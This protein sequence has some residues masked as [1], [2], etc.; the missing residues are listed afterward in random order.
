MHCLCGC[1]GRRS[2]LCDIPARRP[3]LHTCMQLT[4]RS[5]LS[6]RFSLEAWSYT[7]VA[8]CRSHGSFSGDNGSHTEAQCRPEK[9]GEER[10][11]RGRTSPR[12]GLDAPHAALTTTA[13]FTGWRYQ[14]TLSPCSLRHPK[15]CSW[16]H[17]ITC[18]AAM[19]SASAA[20]SVSVTCV[21]H[22]V[23]H[24][25][26]QSGSLVS[27][28][29]ASGANLCHLVLSIPTHFARTSCATLYSTS[30][31]ASWNHSA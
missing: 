30:S 8:V 27:L 31:A 18:R 17:A 26:S 16:V 25:I 13:R 5:R 7:I 15:P 4:C 6:S 29:E 11:R 9:A 28:S 19:I 3:I 21:C 2:L 24:A 22:R 23:T 14:I 20:L 10:D 12:G 1:S